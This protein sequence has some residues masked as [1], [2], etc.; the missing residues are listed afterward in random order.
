MGFSYVLNILHALCVHKIIMFI[1]RSCPSDSLSSSKQEYV[2][3]IVHQN[4]ILYNLKLKFYIDLKLASKCLNASLLFMNIYMKTVYTDS[5]MF[6]RMH[7]SRNAE[8]LAGSE[9]M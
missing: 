5:F 7:M 6:T 8:G 9:G 1:L 2:V 3:L 4:P